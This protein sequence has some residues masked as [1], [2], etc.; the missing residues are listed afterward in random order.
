MKRETIKKMVILAMLMALSVVLISAVH[1]PLLPSVSFLEYDPG[2]VP[3]LI[4][5]MAYGPVAGLMLTVV[6]AFIQGTFI[7]V[8]GPWGIVMHIIGTGSM[9]LA[10]GCVYKVRHTKGGAVAG[11]ILATLVR[12]LVMIPANHF[13]TPIWMGAPV[14]VVD[15]LMLSGIIPLNLIK[16]AINSGLTFVLYK[17]VSRHLVHGDPFAG[18]VKETPADVSGQQT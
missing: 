16:A 4:A 6:A 13:I 18:R 12:A 11:L 5:T 1:T 10:A 17:A 3:I 9:V 15:S 2:D 8:T 7:S 14:E